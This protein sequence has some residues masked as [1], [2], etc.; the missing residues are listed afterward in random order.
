M[1]CGCYGS[2]W[3]RR[4]FIFLQQTTLYGL[5][6]FGSG[7][8]KRVK[9]AHSRLLLLGNSGCWL[10]ITYL[11][12]QSQ[13]WNR[14]RSRSVQLQIWRHQLSACQT[15]ALDIHGAVRSSS[16][17]SCDHRGVGRA[18]IRHFDT[19]SLALLE[20][21]KPNQHKDL[22]CKSPG[23]MYPRRTNIPTEEYHVCSVSLEPFK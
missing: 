2:I 18:T 11:N 8:T 17:H 23:S 13:A 21:R 14:P 9:T 10:A 19:S 6:V 5:R 16:Q 22:C 15:Q 4:H 20:A 1:D 3:H 7:R 12:F